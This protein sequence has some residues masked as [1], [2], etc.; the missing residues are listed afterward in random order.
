MVV[1]AW[2][3]RDHQSRGVSA[4]ELKSRRGYTKRLASM[5]EREAKLEQ[6]RVEAAAAKETKGGR[7]AKVKA[8]K[9]T[10]PT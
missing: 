6:L 5:V 8:T 10:K 2:N 9:A 4:T 7:K 1:E 3:L